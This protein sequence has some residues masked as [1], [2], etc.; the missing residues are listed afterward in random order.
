MSTLPDP[1]R[2]EWFVRSNVQELHPGMVLYDN[3]E[4]CFYHVYDTT[5]MSVEL[6]SLDGNHGWK[7]S[8]E[9]IENNLHD[10]YIPCEVRA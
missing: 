7:E 8:I 4:D 10:R 9:D 2:N 5:D 6:H 1:Y 3:Q